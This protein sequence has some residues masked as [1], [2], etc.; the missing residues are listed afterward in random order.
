MTNKYKRVAYNSYVYQ[1]VLPKGD[2]DPALKIRELI[3]KE[4]VTN[5]FWCG[6]I[7]KAMKMARTKKGNSGVNIN[8][9]ANTFLIET[10]KKRLAKAKA[11]N[12]KNPAINRLRRKVVGTFG[13]SFTSKQTA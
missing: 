3:E 13:K 12:A 2:A 4:G 5:P 10:L 7:Q 9:T 6:D 8:I 11:N 1:A